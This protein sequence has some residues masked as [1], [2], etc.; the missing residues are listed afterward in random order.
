MNRASGTAVIL[1][2]KT[3]LIADVIKELKGLKLSEYLNRFY[4]IEA[5]MN[6]IKFSDH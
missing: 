1:A 4:F 6:Y 3:L 5:L 2:N